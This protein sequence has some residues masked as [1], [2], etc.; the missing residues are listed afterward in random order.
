MKHA[1]CFLGIVFITVLFVFLIYLELWYFDTN[2]I[3]LGNVDED[4]WMGSFQRWALICV[5][6]AGF[7]SL[8]WYVLA[9]WIFKINKWEDAGKRLI[10]ILLLFVPIIGI[11]LSVIFVERA[12]SGL[13]FEQWMFFMVNGLLSYYLATSLF[14]PSSFKYTPVGAKYIRHW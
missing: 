7:A 13:R 14:S 3:E 11:V 8:L 2:P 4:K 1:G 12:Q 6:A 5:G 9:Q 10:W